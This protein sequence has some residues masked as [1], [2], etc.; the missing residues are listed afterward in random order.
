MTDTAEELSFEDQIAIAT[1]Y[2]RMEPSDRR[3]CRN[4]FCGVPLA[5]ANKGEYCYRHSQL[6]Q[7]LK[8]E[9]A[10]NKSEVAPEDRARVCNVMNC[11]TPVANYS[12]SG[13]C[14]RHTHLARGMQLKDGSIPRPFKKHELPLPMVEP[15]KEEV[16]LVTEETNPPARL[17]AVE[18][19]EAKLPPHNVSGRC[20]R[21]WYVKK[22]QRMKD[23]TI[24]RPIAA[25][26]AAQ[27]PAPQSTPFVPKP[28]KTIKQ[29]IQEAVADG[30]KIAQVLPPPE[31]KPRT[32]SVPRFESICVPSPEEIAEAEEMHG[33]SL[34]NSVESLLTPV[35]RTDTQKTHVTPDPPVW[36]RDTNFVSMNVPTEALDRFWARMTVDDKLRIIEREIFGS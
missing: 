13:R 19:C 6:A 24:L 29:T 34:L 17:C 16:S 35:L 10:C 23:G 26:G 27:P 2:V 18:E 32:G 20:S 28:R 7:A 25:V 4:E 12:S 8:Y 33:R 1:S 30:I 31:I 36:L 15:V 14:A 11:D 9:K 5:N 3:L 22:G 21:H